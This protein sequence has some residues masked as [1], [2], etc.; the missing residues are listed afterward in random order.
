MR[1]PPSTVTSTSI[2]QYFICARSVGKVGPPEEEKGVKHMFFLFLENSFPRAAW[3][4]FD[5]DNQ[6]V[7]THLASNIPFGSF[8]RSW[9]GGKDTP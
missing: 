9:D 6:S 2:K 8:Q 7:R 4:L 1:P 5:V 3:N